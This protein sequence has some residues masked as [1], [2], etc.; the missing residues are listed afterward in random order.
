MRVLQRIGYY[1]DFVKVGHTV[2]ALPFCLIPALVIR[3]RS[4][5]PASALLWIVAA[6]AGARGFAMAVNR[7]LDRG[8]DAENP[9]TAARH[10]PS[11]L[12]SLPGAA[13]FAAVC[14]AL[15]ILAAARLSPL[16]LALA[17]AV[18]VILAAYSWCKRFTALS[19]LVLGF[20]LSLAPLGVEIALLGRVTPPTGVLALAV[21]FW[22][23]GFDIFYAC[24]D[25][26]FDRRA[27]L[28][29]IPAQLGAPRALALARLLHAAVFLLFILYGA[30]TPELGTAYY[31]AQLVVLGLLI[32]EHKLAASGDPARI[33]MAFF[34][35]NGIISLIQLAAVAADLAR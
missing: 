15:F 28:H 35:L 3:A 10:L 23:A 32:Y 8:Y 27:G 33:E 16:C 29:S 18:L 11:G 1:L 20:C 17:P 13:A 6:F 5:V 34:N 26:D 22:V 25:I 14:A 21:L 19:H 12:I 9:R 4:G 31:A 2:F 7:I 24:M 30:L